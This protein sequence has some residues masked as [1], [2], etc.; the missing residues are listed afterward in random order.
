MEREKKEVSLERKKNRETRK[1]GFRGEVYLSDEIALVR[2]EVVLE[3]LEVYF[4][5]FGFMKLGFVF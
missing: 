5:P 2:Y 3:I 4:R 1:L